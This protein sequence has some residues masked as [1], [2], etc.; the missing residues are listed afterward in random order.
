MLLRTPL[1]ERHQ[2]LGARL[3]DFG[4]WE[5]PLH[6][7]SQVDE[8]HV[9]RTSAGVFDVSH[10]RVLDLAGPQA[11]GF[12]QRLLS[13]DV[14]RLTRPGSALYSCMLNEAGGVID[15]LIVYRRAM[16]YRI[17]VNAGTAESDVRW[18]RLQAERWDV[19]LLG[20]SDL[21]ILAVQGP[22]ALSMSAPAFG[23][24]FA[25]ITA[26]KRFEAVD[27]VP[28]AGGFCARTGYTGED[29]YELMLSAEDA[30]PF[31]DAL[32]NAGVRP[33]GLGARDTLR[34]EAGMS[35]YGH[36]LDAKT[37]PLES[38]LAWTVAMQDDR[39]FIGRAALERQIR[40]G[41]HPRLVGLVL[42]DRGVLRAGMTVRS[43]AGEGVV[44]SGTFSPSLGCSIALARVPAET[45][46]HVQVEVRGKPLNARV[47]T[48]PFVRNG[49]NLISAS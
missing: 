30:G 37:T 47:V 8:H 32:L 42:E 26:L 16:G 48:P 13:N 35:L 45:G 38:G 10:M 39:V 7:G 4:G 25:R 21:A 34:L 5:M 14:T 19:E 41:S 43:P 17:V 46:V 9:V 36:E 40:Q 1:F 18:M 22:A 44:T 23:V 3:V 11:S 12:L 27:V 24:P 31:W 6:Y 29:G 28:P 2:A 20:R 15:D 33:C 49:L